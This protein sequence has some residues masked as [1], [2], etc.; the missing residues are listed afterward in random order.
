MAT[1]MQISK[2]M[3]LDIIMHPDKN[4]VLY[5]GD[6]APSWPDNHIMVKVDAE[7]TDAS[8]KTDDKEL[9]KLK[10]SAQMPQ[11]QKW[12]FIIIAAFLLIIF[13]IL[14]AISFSPE[15]TEMQV[16]LF[17]FCVDTGTLLV[18]AIIGGFVGRATAVGQSQPK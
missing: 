3:F 10:A 11:Y 14:L 1:F 13:G 7:K 5:F 12:G 18:G 6:D 4:C 9:E 16:G 17:N 8:P 15:P 2:A